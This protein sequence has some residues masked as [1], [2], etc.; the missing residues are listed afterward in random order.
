ML[1]NLSGKIGDRFSEAVKLTAFVNG[2]SLLKIP[3][4]A[5]TSPR[6]IE[7]NEHTA[8]VGMRLD[9]RTRNHVGVMYFGALA[10]GAE[11][12]I[13]AK[14]LQEISRSGQKIDFI[15]KDFKCEFL[16]MT[17]DHVHFIC[18]EAADVAALVH[19]SA[20]TSDRVTQT[21][22]GFA[23]VPTKSDQP[24]MTYELTLSMRNRSRRP[25]LGKN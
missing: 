11:L 7:I 17:D 3:L 24:V 13:A 25:E 15:F 14:A 9:W 5:F 1:E 8:V 19:K 20:E 18:N 6:I 22:K 12:S 4:L 16:R 23:V 21:F 2:L 10:M